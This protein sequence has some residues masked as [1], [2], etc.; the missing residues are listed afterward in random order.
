MND[1]FKKYRNHPWCGFGKS[2]GNFALANYK[3][4]DT[5]DLA[6]VPAEE[7]ELTDDKWSVQNFM[8]EDGS[9]DG[10]AGFQQVLDGKPL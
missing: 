2:R 9:Y 4:G 6:W 1:Q 5:I 7:H 10:C 8:R 3:F